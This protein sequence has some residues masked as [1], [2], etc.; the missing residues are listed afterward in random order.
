MPHMVIA[1]RLRD[2]RVVF[3]DTAGHWVDSI[4][5]GA[6]WDPGA[7]PAAL[8]RAKQ[9]E[10]QSVVVDPNVIDVELTDQGRLPV[11]IREAIRAF[12]PSVGIDP[13]AGGG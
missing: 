5:H 1:N 12:G 10:T 3:L 9:D 8:E 11:A 4:D 13:T 2:G 6:L 7:S